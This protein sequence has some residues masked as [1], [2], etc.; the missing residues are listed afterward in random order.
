MLAARP[1]ATLISESKSG[2]A[3]AGLVR[4]LRGGEARSW[5]FLRG[6]ASQLM[7]G[8][9]PAATMVLSG[10]DIA[11]LQFD[12]VWDGEHLWLQDPLRLART[13][14]NGHLLNEW[15]PVVGHAV[16]ACGQARVLALA[17]GPPPERRAP[18]SAVLETLRDMECGDDPWQAR[19]CQTVRIVAPRRQ[20]DAAGPQRTPDCK[21]PG[22]GSK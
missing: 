1:R 8:S 21:L 16:V 10:W 14:V 15:L 13:F 2:R 12:V 19:D 9:S 17:V 7:A 11:P 3:Q 22:R 4:V 6:V 18:A 20:S 5:T